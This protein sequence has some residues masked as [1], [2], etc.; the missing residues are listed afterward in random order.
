YATTHAT[1]N[2]PPNSPDFEKALYIAPQRFPY[3]IFY[4]EQPQLIRV[5]RVL[6]T[7]S[8]IDHRFST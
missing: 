3:L 5:V 4:V 7:S 6:H 1:Q 2:S 8:N